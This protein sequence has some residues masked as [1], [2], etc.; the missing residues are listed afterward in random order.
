MLICFPVLRDEGLASEVFGHFGS[1]PAFL[2]I[3]VATGALT[4]L[5]N[6]NHAHQHGACNPLAGLAGYEV[7]A[8]AVGGIGRG[9]LHKLHTAGLR[10]FQARTGT[11]AENLALF[12]ADEL[13]EFQASQCCGAHGHGCAH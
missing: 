7:D 9:A 3:D 4:A 6:G 2:L 8:V 5:D 1:A 13:P 10:V 12:Q 11:V